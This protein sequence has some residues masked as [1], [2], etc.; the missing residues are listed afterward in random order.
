[1]ALCLIQRDTGSLNV[2]R[3]MAK[4]SSVALV[5]LLV[6]LAGCAD[7]GSLRALLDAATGLPKSPTQVPQELATLQLLHWFCLG[8]GWHPATMGWGACVAQQQTYLASATVPID[9]RSLSYARYLIARAHDWCAEN[10]PVAPSQA[11]ASCFN[12]TL[13]NIAAKLKQKS[14]LL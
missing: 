1:M 12:R 8:Q 13:T 7:G 10:G 14:V 3:A 11:F 2:R 6:A 4:K 9:Q 5:L